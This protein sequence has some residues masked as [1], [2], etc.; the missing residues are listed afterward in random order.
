MK[1]VLIGLTIVLAVIGAVVFVVSNRTR[2]VRR[3]RRGRP[4]PPQ[5]T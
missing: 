4:C 1:K 2:G 5:T 3:R